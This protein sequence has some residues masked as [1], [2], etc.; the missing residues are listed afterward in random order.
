MKLI[1]AAPTSFKERA[2]TSAINLNKD[3]SA[4]IRNEFANQ[5]ENMCKLERRYHLSAILIAK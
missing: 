2:T 4:N 1:S 5:D 3:V